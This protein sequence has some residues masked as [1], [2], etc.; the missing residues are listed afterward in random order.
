MS[1]LAFIAIAMLV[2][3]PTGAAAYLAAYDS[4]VWLLTLPFTALLAA[5][6]LMPPPAGGA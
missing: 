6:V 4:L 2:Q 3:V 1:R 5:L